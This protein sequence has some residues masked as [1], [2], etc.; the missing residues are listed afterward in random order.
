MTAHTI[1]TSLGQ[2]YVEIDGDGEPMLLLPSLLTDHTLYARQVSHFSGRYLT[3]AVDPP[4]QGRSEPLDRCFTFE[5]SARA[6]VEIL[7]ALQLPQAHVVGNSWGAM[8]GGTI[9]ATYPGRVG[10]SVL[11]NGT[12]S[13]APRWDRLQLALLAHMTRRVGRPLLVR[14]AIVPRFLGATTRRQQPALVDGLAAMIRRN[15]ARSAS[16]A[17]ESIVIRRPD[18]HRL[19]EHI[20][21]PTLVIAGREDESSP[22]PEVRRMAE[23]IP[24]AE[25]VILEQVGHLAA[26]EAADTINGLID[27]FIHRNTT[28]RP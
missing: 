12:A 4:G 20:T 14:S 1:P 2:L 21:T 5:E 9:A 23:A 10:C 6:Y 7:D 19:F 28:R 25:L 11:M 17:V 15:N 8:I 24:G 16:F 18:Q 13:P 27:D 22:V 26:Y 3:I